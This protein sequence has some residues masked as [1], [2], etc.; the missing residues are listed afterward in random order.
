VGHSKNDLTDFTLYKMGVRIYKRRYPVFKKK[1]NIS[2]G[3]WAVWK[4]IRDLGL[5]WRK[6]ESERHVVIQKDEIRAARPA[7]L[8]DLSRYRHEG[9]ISSIRMERTFTAH[10]Q[11]IKPGVLV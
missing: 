6:L 3:K 8:S 5:R 4:I 11:K 9:T 10:T 7:Y 1:I 2:G